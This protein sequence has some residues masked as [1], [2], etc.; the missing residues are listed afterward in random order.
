[1]LDFEIIINFEIQQARFSGQMSLRIIAE[2]LKNV[3]V[4][5]KRFRKSRSERAIIA[6]SEL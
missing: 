2:L 6:Q 3:L 4:F 1:M 5:L